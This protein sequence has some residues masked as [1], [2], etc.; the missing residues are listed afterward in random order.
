VKITRLGEPA[1][2]IFVEG[3]IVFEEPYGWFRGRQRAAIKGPD[4]DPAK[5]QNISQQIGD[6]Q[7]ETTMK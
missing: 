2:A 7:R 4:H 5:G 1:D 3:H 6:C